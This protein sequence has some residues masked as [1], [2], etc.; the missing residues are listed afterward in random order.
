MTCFH[1]TVPGDETNLAYKATAL[2]CQ[3][4]V[5]S[6][7]GYCPGMRQSRERIYVSLPVVW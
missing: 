3:E 4:A 7:L 2:L 1:P 6:V 5:L